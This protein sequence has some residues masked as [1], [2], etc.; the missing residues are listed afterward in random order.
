VNVTVMPQL[1]PAARLG[2][3]VLVF[4]KSAALGPLKAICQR[5]TGLLPK[6]LSVTVFGG[7]LVPTL[8]LGKL[9][10]V[11]DKLTAVPT[12]V[13]RM[14]SESPELSRRLIADRRGPE[15][16]G[17]KVALSWQLAPAAKVLGES[18]Q[19]LLWLKSLLSEPAILM[20]VMVRLAFP[21]LLTV[22]VCAPLVVPRG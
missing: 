14:K 20:D 17:T 18:G 6:L 5:F 19:L 16:V 2:P 7:P 1:L 8:W 11:G 12:P 21:L 22:T 15:A 9:R 13:K 10:L 4:E 3:Q